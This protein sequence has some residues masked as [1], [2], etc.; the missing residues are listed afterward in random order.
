MPGSTG[1]NA[2]LCEA[3]TRG[4]ANGVLRPLC[5]DEKED[6]DGVASP[7]ERLRGEFN[8]RLD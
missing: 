5:E 4:C 6:N 8:S 1:T 3:A 7:V 2:E